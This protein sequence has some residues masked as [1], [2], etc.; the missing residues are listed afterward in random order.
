[1]P[2][3]RPVIE[4]KAYPIPTAGWLTVKSVTPIKIGI[5]FNKVQLNLYDGMGRLVE[6][7]GTTIEQ[8]N[9]GLQM[10]LQKQ[11]A[12]AYILEVVQNAQFI[13]TIKIIKSN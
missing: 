9:D 13:Q 8:L 2:A 12:G 10:N 1:V 5:D 3:E 6:S 4:L 7:I 11:A